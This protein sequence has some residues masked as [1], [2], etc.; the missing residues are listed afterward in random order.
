M[1]IDI[2]NINTIEKR[3][4][5]YTQ[6]CREIYEVIQ[7]FFDETNIFPG[8][9]IKHFK[10]NAN[11]THNIPLEANNNIKRM[12]LEKGFYAQVIILCRK[13]L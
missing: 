8:D 3:Y 13:D 2:E 1:N 6:R 5:V 7:L 12:S 10:N 11:K 4:K 9:F